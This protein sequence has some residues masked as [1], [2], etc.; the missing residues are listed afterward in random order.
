MSDRSD[1]IAITF[2]EQSGDHN[3]MRTVVAARRWM[4]MPRGPIYQGWP[5]AVLNQIAFGAF[6]RAATM[7]GQPS[8]LTSLNAS[9]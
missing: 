3:V 7:S 9:P 4:A 5:G 6:E 8:P 2:F 1:A